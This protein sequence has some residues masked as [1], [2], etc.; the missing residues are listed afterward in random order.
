MTPEGFGDPLLRG[1]LVELAVA[2]VIGTAST[3]VV[4]RFTESW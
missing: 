1:D 2:V 4:D 3:A